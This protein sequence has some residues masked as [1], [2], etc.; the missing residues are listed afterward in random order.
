[1]IWCTLCGKCGHMDT[2][3]VQSFLHQR[4]FWKQH[5][6]RFDNSHGLSLK[7]IC[8]VS[9]YVLSL[10]RQSFSC[11]PGSAPAYRSFSWCSHPNSC[12]VVPSF[13][14]LGFACIPPSWG[15]VRAPLLSSGRMSFGSLTSLFASAQYCWKR[16]TADYWMYCLITFENLA[17]QVS[18]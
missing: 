17:R 5:Q 15:K 6:S 8:G 13:A 18:S 11:A 2:Q 1:M 9:T 3:R 14:Q 16:I 10:V 4:A 7:A 12:K